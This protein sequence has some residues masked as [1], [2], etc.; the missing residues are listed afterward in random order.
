MKRKVGEQK[1]GAL[2]F[3]LV[4]ARAGRQFSQKKTEQQVFY[5]RKILPILNLTDKNAGFV[6]PFV[7]ANEKSIPE[8]TR[9][10]PDFWAKKSP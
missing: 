9:Q 1:T 4:V 7:S 3:G 5:A 10:K 2:K 6:P 8:N